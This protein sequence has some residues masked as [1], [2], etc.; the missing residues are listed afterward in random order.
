MER[1]HLF[2]WAVLVTAFL[3]MLSLPVFTGAITI[4]LIHQRLNNFSFGL[5]GGRL[6]LH[7]ITQEIGKI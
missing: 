4:F 6:I 5:A 3:L 2:V 7:I 1:A